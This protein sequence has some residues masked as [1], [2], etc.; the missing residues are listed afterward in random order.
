MTDGVRDVHGV[1]TPT[2]NSRQDTLRITVDRHND[3][4]KPHTY[5]PSPTVHEPLTTDGG[6]RTD[7]GPSRVVG[8]HVQAVQFV[9]REYRGPYRRYRDPFVW[10]FSNYT[11]FTTTKGAKLHSVPFL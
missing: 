8:P 11:W 6:S 3:P 9:D 1:E 2:R 10:V 5:V 4:P 7:H